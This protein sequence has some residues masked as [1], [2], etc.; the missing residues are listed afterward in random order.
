MQRV[1]FLIGRGDDHQ[2]GPKLAKDGAFHARQPP[3]IHMLD[4]LEQHGRIEAALGPVALLERAEA[5]VQALV[6]TQEVQAKPL[7]G[8]GQGLGIDVHALQ[9]GELAVLPKAQQ[10]LAAATTKVR[11]LARACGEERLEHRIH[12]R[13][14]QDRGHR[15]VPSRNPV[16]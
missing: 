10:Q 12:A 6:A 4:G 14:M 13:T 1:V 7:A 5:H 2:V 9:P 3:R 15:F 11:H 8:R 16:R